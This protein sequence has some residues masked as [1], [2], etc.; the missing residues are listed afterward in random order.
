MIFSLTILA[1]GRLIPCFKPV[2]GYGFIN[3]LPPAGLKGLIM[4]KDI[5]EE[6]YQRGYSL[7]PLKNNT[8]FP[9]IRWKKYQYRRAGLEEILKW[10][11]TFSEPNIGLVTGKKLVVIDL[12]DIE[13]LSELLRI[14]PGIDKTTRVRTKRPGYHF[15]FSNNGHRIRSTKTL[16]DL[17]KVE[18]Y[19]E[20]RQVVAPPSK[21][22]G[23][24]YNFKVPLSEIQPLPK[25][26]IK[27][28]QIIGEGITL[29][30]TGIKE[31]KQAP[32]VEYKK[33]KV[34]S[35]PRYNG[36]DRY[37]MKQILDKDLQV[38]ERDISLFILYGLLCQ[39][40]NRSGHAKK[41]VTLKNNSL[42]K[43]LTDPEMEK[44]FRGRYN[45]KCSKVTETLPFIECDKCKFKFKGGRLR[46]GNIIVKNIM[47]IPKLNT[48]EK[49][50]LL[51]LGTVFEGEEVSIS[52]ISLKA[53]MDYRTVEKAIT[54]LKKKGVIDKN[55][56]L[57][58]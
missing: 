9:A 14:L 38:G 31:G 49:A 45:F 43:P 52:R 27:Q 44:V 2:G 13:K 53:K 51:L 33:R 32:G 54:G 18:L 56:F 26:I 48:C 15:Y 39:N 8:K 19:A 50:I 23:F 6:Y 36:L 3:P 37:C 40:K 42:S 24:T 25:Q 29:P 57:K 41:I 22:D 17:E 1:G 5:I 46:M 4:N 7:I 12:D 28:Y 21:I 34:L 11:I 20:R 58:E 30:G 55:K 10:F 47:R 16:F 35:L